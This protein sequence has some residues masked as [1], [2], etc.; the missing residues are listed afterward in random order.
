MTEPY[1]QAKNDHWS[2][3]ISILMMAIFFIA[4]ILLFRL[5]QKSILEHQHYLAL[6]KE[7]YYIQEE[8][9]SQR[10]KIYAQDFAAHD[11]YPIATNMEKYA[12][13]VVPRNIKNKPEMAEKLAPIL[14]MDK[15]EIFN[16]INNDKPYIPPLKRKLEKE[17][18]NQIFELK[19]NLTGVYIMPE[20]I[21][22][23]PEENL[24]SHLLGFVNAEG[25]GNYGIEGY[26]DEQ[27]R[28]RGGMMI[29]EKDTLGRVI[30]MVQTEEVRDGTDLLLTID[31]NVQYIAEQKLRK[32]I[33]KYQAD[34]GSI[35]IIEP[36]TGKIIAMAASPDFNPN[37]FNEIPQEQQ[38]IFLNPVIG[39]VWEPGSI[40]KPIV[41]S[42][43]L[44]EGKVEPDTEGYF[45]NMV[46]VQGY[47][48]HTAQDK[49]F[50]RE[51]M[52]QVL[53]NSDNVAMVWVADQI[54]NETMYKY[55]DDYSFGHKTGID[56]EGET[57]G[58][59]L[60]LKE[61]RDIYRATMAFGQG[62]SLTP[63][64]MVSA[65][66]AIA[67]N[68]FLMKPY[69]VEKMVR[70]EKGESITQPQE[71]RRVLSEDTANKL[72]G[73]LVSV[74]ERGHGKKAAVEGYKI[75]G[76]TGTA[77]IPKPAEEGGGYY[78]DKHTGSFAGFFPADNPKFAMLVK[79]TDPK[80]TEW[81]ESS[82]AP[83]FGE[84]AKWLLDYYQIPPGE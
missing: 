62:I 68:G 39:H 4:G 34:D 28:G 81:A 61:W 51:T 52:T 46:V 76:K 49:A 84:M 26:Y 79:L 15:E 43:A 33:E 72:K 18:I 56:L 11:Q 64:Q 23:Y 74:V 40:F 25:K 45:T 47:E 22:Y 77:Q 9:P 67:N 55:I 3:R 83:T 29:G 44:N 7:Q 17:K 20:S 19:I 32:A 14:E 12:V 73:M 78:D 37:K 35:I 36:Q 6:A 57:T 50:G 80:N 10:G 16:Q 58:S 27:L 66:A 38:S 69:V 70:P 54:G 2:R 42:A 71:I 24:A 53:E 82:A 41:M 48:I 31:H 63:L 1:T 60:E 5:F 8:N 13:S 65:I 59:V 21:R 75:A 30:S